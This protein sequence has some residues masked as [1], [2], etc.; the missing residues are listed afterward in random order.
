MARALTGREDRADDLA[1][2]TIAH[3]LARAPD[4]AT[5]LGYAHATMTRLWL[6][7]QRALGRRMRRLAE[8]AAR[9]VLER[10][11][12]PGAS[13]PHAARHAME[14]LPPARRA[15]LSLRVVGGLSYEQI[16]RSLGV[17]VATVRSELH[18]ARK[19]VRS[20]TEAQP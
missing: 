2:Q 10:R 16:A 8:L 11:P 1:Q 5:H 17:S 6:D 19:A 7:D 9:T 4:K 3:L 12:P 14:A 18:E 13:E 20:R 15:I